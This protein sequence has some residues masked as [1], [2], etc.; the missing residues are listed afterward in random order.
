MLTLQ[1]PQLVLVISFYTIRIGAY[2]SSRWGFVV[3][4]FRTLPVGNIRYGFSEHENDMH[5]A[6]KS[7]VLTYRVSSFVRRFSDFIRRFVHL[8]NFI[9][10]LPLL[11][12]FLGSNTAALVA[13]GAW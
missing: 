6:S 10:L 3:E 1:L 5:C 9:Q 12:H 4:V 2:F 8:P 13:F 11:G 7:N